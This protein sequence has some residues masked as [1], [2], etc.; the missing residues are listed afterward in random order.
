M[1]NRTLTITLKG[2]REKKSRHLLSLYGKECYKNI[3]FT[4]E[5]IFTV[6]ETFTKQNDT[7]YVPS[8]KKAHNLV[9]SIKRGHYP[10]L[11]GSV[12]WHLLFLKRELKQWR[13]II[14]STF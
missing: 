1:T 2:N 8:S 13:K 11:L 10:G 4:D 9:P 6:A 7:F 14:R 5:K 12:L 3:L